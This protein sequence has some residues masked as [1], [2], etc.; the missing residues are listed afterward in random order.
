VSVIYKRCSKAS[1]P[2]DFIR[3][4]LPIRLMSTNTSQQA[5]SSLLQFTGTGK[6]ELALKYGFN[7]A[8]ALIVPIR[9][10]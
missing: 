9:Y 3:C 6:T 10:R 4:H 7:D 2:K 8:L 5:H 1:E